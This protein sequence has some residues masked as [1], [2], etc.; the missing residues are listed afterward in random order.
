VRLTTGTG[1]V[2]HATA[3]TA[4]GYYS[5][6]DRRVHLGLGDEAAIRSIQIRWPSGAVQRLADVAADRVL[7][8]TE[9]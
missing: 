3:R 1:Q 7:T 6:G 8:V 4:G 5:A 9:P 2:R